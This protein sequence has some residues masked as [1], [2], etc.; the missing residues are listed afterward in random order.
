[1]G[2]VDAAEEAKRKSVLTR[3]QTTVLVKLVDFVGPGG[4]EIRDKNVEERNQA[5]IDEAEKRGQDPGV[6]GRVVDTGY[7]IMNNAR[8]V[9]FDR[10]VDDLLAAGLKLVDCYREC[11][12]RGDKKQIIDTIMAFSSEGEAIEMPRELILVINSHRAAHCTVFANWRY[13]NPEDATAGQ[14]RLDTINLKGV[15]EVSNNNGVQIVVK[16]NTYRLQNATTGE[17]VSVA[18]TQPKEGAAK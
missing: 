2:Y 1:M 13:R 10:L 18:D 3:K 7:Q 14:F 17:S 5:L 16:G 6:Y 8:M 9:F 4:L 12:E 11:Y 15:R